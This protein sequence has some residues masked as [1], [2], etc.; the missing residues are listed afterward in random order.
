M[1]KQN[2]DDGLHAVSNHAS[3]L[4]PRKCTATGQNPS[5]DTNNAETNIW[6]PNFAKW[7]I[8]KDFSEEGV[9][10]FSYGR[11]LEFLSTNFRA[12]LFDFNDNG[13]D[14]E[15]DGDSDNITFDWM[16]GTSMNTDDE[17]TLGNQYR[18]LNQVIQLYNPWQDTEI[19]PYTTMEVKFKMKT[20]SKLY[21][22]EN[23]PMVEIAIIDGDSNTTNPLRTYDFI[24]SGAQDR[25]LPYAGIHGYWPHGDF[26]STRYNDSMNGV[27]TLNRK[28]SNFG[29]MNRFQNTDTDTWETFSYQFTMGDIFRYGGSTP[30]IIRPFYLI[31]QS[32]DN[33]Y[34]RVWLD[35][36]EVYESQDFIPDVDVRKKISIGKF[37]KG[38][39]TNY[40]D[41]NILSQL[42]AYNDTTAPLEAQ[43]YFYPQY[44]SD[45][46]FDVKRTPM[47]NDFKKGLFYIY[48]VD[49]GDGSPKE[50]VSE[51]E[52]IDEE[53]VILHTYETSGVFEVTGRMIR[54]KEDEFGDEIGI[55]KNKKFRLRINVN[56]GVDEDFR[57]F[58]SDGFSFIP[59]K[60]TTPTIGGHSKE[61]AYYKGI[62]RQLGFIGNDK[63]TIFFKNPGD[64]LR[65]EIALN[66]MDS[67]FNFELDL[68]MEYTTPR[69]LQKSLEII[70]PICDTYDCG[71]NQF[72]ESSK[73]SP[74]LVPTVDN[75]LPEQLSNLPF[76]SNLSEFDLNEDNNISNVDATKWNLDY[77]RP[78]ISVFLLAYLLIANIETPTQE[79][80]YAMID[81]LQ[82]QNGTSY[83]I[84]QNITIPLQNITDLRE[85]DY[86]RNP[87]Q[88]YTAVLTCSPLDVECVEFY[89]NGAITQF[90]GETWNLENLSSMVEGFT[91]R[92]GI[93]ESDYQGEFC[94]EALGCDGLGTGTGIPFVGGVE[95]ID[96]DEDGIDDTINL[97]SNYVDFTMPSSTE[98]AYTGF[99]IYSEE[100]GKG[101]GDCDLTSIKYYNTPK[102]IWEMFGFEEEDLEQIGNPDDERYW[103]N[104]IPENYSIY[105]REGIVDGE[106]VDF[107]SEQEWLQGY[108]Y[109]VLPKYGNNGEFFQDVDGEI[110]PNPY[111][112]NNIPYPLESSITDE[113]EFNKD[114]LINI[115]SETIET[116]T[117]SDNSGNQNYGFGFVDYKPEF[118]DKTSRPKKRKSMKTIKSAT[119]NGAF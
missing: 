98:F 62:K 9:S 10:C 22:S 4:T 30:T 39:L 108:Y 90:D 19:N 41:P 104:I 111:P 82:E 51:P 21:N 23:P 32:T 64:K 103:K 61:S 16:N 101:I 81:S 63:T 31:V 79:T 91:Y 47:Y 25:D 11:C 109:P 75:V 67:S 37:G 43:F 38:D 94:N 35:D 89:G 85:F 17:G 56:E 70:E 78:D 12:G 48:D 27:G 93:F 115:T 42:D 96:T 28:Y 66:K 20:W 59:H 113:K 34:G 5:S 46:L 7:I 88:T 13:S 45:E 14:D 58:G 118:D 29:S 49:W 60:N 53:K 76:P 54:T 74:P 69:P 119:N 18:S 3:Y 112:N 117:F 72:L 36:F 77:S 95:L 2:T 97:N 107:G 80:V 84:P 87:I 24:Y 102:S 65:T 50:F 40:Y 92:F 8:D 114:L 26:N 110:V 106:L 55:I 100:L 33:F 1:G 116:N 86:F 71:V 15:G 68:L 52:P 83:V 6:F 99:N 44:K 73:F 105:N 57:Y